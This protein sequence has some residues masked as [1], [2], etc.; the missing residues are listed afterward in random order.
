MY[1]TIQMN[2]YQA[3]KTDEDQVFRKDVKS[4][5]YEDLMLAI[6]YLDN[7]RKTISQKIDPNHSLDDKKSDSILKKRVAY[8]KKRVA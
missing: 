6:R 1:K 2:N 7:E 8:L 3:H 5:S 4:M